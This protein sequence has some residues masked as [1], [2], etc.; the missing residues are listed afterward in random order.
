MIICIKCGGFISRDSSNL[1]SICV[2]CAGKLVDDMTSEDLV[3][4]AKV[5]LDAVIDEATGYQAMRHPQELA[6]RHKEYRW[7]K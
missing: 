1:E 3:A 4:M 2:E 7:G 5:G 6:K